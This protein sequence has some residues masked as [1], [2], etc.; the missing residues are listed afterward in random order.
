MGITLQHAS[1]GLVRA[2]AGGRERQQSLLWL[3]TSGHAQAEPLAPGAC[4]AS[5]QSRTRASVSPGRQRAFVAW[6]AGR[7][8]RRQQ[9][10]TSGSRRACLPKRGGGHS[11]SGRRNEPTGSAAAARTSQAFLSILAARSRLNPEQAVVVPGEWLCGSSAACKDRSAG[12]AQTHSTGCTRPDPG[13]DVGD[14][15]LLLRSSRVGQ[16]QGVR[17]HCVSEN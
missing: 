15:K 2:E 17:E 5:G 16:L 4:L 14:V 11:S 6:Q 13:Q 3:N 12:T 9:C 1:P 8:C 10:V 7:C